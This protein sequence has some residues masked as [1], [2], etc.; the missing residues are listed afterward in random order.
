VFHQFLRFAREPLSLGFVLEGLHVDQHVV[1]RAPCRGGRKQ[2]G[3]ASIGYSISISLLGD[4]RRKLCDFDGGARGL[5]RHLG[6]L[7][8]RVRNGFGATSGRGLQH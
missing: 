8:Q 4:E 6:R 1:R 2:R 7:E 3:D 5:E